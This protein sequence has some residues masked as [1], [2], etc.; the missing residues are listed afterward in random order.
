M[1]DWSSSSLSELLSDLV[2]R[3]TL[4]SQGDLFRIRTWSRSTTPDVG[5]RWLTVDTLTS[6]T[7]WG[8]R[9]QR[10]RHSNPHYYHTCSV[11]RILLIPSFINI[12]GILSRSVYQFTTFHNNKDEILK[13]VNKKF[14]LFFLRTRVKRPKADLLNLL[15]CSETSRCVQ[16]DWWY[17]T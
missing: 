10:K 9:S 5:L 13:K 16:V 4:K 8:A 15:S 2:S 14:N 17:L 6:F 3:V 12:S 11:P 1:I 7:I